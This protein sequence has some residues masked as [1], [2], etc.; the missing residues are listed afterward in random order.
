MGSRH[1]ET[2]LSHRL[3]A[4]AL[5]EDGRV[6]EAERAARAALDI[7]ESQPEPDR[8]EVARDLG[9]L[10]SIA[11]ALGREPEA[12]ELMRRQISLYEAMPEAERPLFE[13]DQARRR[14]AGLT[15]P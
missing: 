12:G 11:L 15:G 4:V 9:V 2:G 7:H 10:A 3:L 13:L 8:R 6:N 14:L 5:L 1:P